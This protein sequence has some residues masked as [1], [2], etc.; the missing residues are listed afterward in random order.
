MNECVEVDGGL[1]PAR[2][3]AGRLIHPDKEG[4]RNFWRWFGNSKMIDEEG[5]P[6]VFYHA[7]TRDFDSFK[8][9]GYD[10]RVS[11]PAMWFSPYADYQAAAHHV[12]SAKRDCRE[13]TR[14][15][16]VYMKMGWPLVIDNQIMLDWAREVFADPPGNINFPQ[17]VHEVSAVSLRECDY[18]GIVFRGELIG[19]GANT[20]EYIVFNPLQVKSAI[21]N[22]GLFDKKTTSLTD[23]NSL[24]YSADLFLRDEAVERPK[25]R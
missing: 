16:P 8:T 14:V 6:L 1:R 15:M 7:T 23:A 25:F 2:N 9:G 19:W 5:R 11:G 17:L 21:G 10:R 24:V 22:S 12:G 4:V 18:D 13:G 20:D 3:S